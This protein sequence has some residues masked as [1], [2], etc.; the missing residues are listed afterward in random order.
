M[1]LIISGDLQHTVTV[2]EMN[3]PFSICLCT[4]E[5]RGPSWTIQLMI[6][7]IFMTLPKAA[8]KVILFFLKI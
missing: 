5:K 8:E 2:V 6:E 3:L 4:G 1:H 7:R